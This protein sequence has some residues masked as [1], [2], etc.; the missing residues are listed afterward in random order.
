M[1]LPKFANRSL[2]NIAISTIRGQYPILINGEKENSLFGSGILL[3]LGKNEITSAT[4][5]QRTVTSATPEASVLI[6]K[7]FFAGFKHHNDLQWMDRTE[8]MFLRSIK[9]L[10][11]Y[12]VMQLRTYESLT[13]LEDF[14]RDHQQ[15]NL[16]LFVDAY[17]Q[18]Q[19]LRIPNSQG[20]DNLLNIIGQA[21]SNSLSNLSYDDYKEDILKILQRN[22]FASDI[23]LST[24]IV[25]PTSIENYSTGPGTGVIELTNISSFSTNTSI[26]TDPSPAS[27]VMID[28]YHIMNISEEDIELAINEA[29]VGSV[30]T[31]RA[32]LDSNVSLDNIDTTSIIA[33]GLELLGLGEFDNTIDVKYIRNQLR[34][35]FLG[36]G[37]VNAGDTVH[38]YIR[39]NKSIHQ[40]DD[41]YDES[42]F[43]VD[44][45]IMEAERILFTNKKIDLKTYI[46]LRKYADPSF[47]FNHVYAGLVKESKEAFSNGSWK[48]TVNLEDNMQWLKW[49]RYMF[50]PAID[51]AQGVLEDPLTPYQVK[52]DATGRV[53]SAGGTQLLE[54]NKQLLRSSLLSYDSGI[55]NGQVATENNLLQGQ[56]NQGGSLRNTKILQ[57]PH[58]LVYRW[59]SGIITVT[60]DLNVID[61]LNEESVSAAIHRK[62]YGLTVAQDVLN[63]L[64]VANILSILIVG[65]PYNVN[66][67]L[68]QSYQ[69]QNYNL[70]TGVSS[71][72]SQN[73]LSS[74]LDV[75]RSQNNYFGN[76]RPYRMITLSNNTM[77]ESFSRHLIRGEVNDKLKVLRSRSLEIARKID[78]LK[79]STGSSNN[80]LIRTLTDE[81]SNIQ[82]TIQSQIK[83]AQTTVLSTGAAL[84]EN[85]NLFGNNRV[86]PLTGNFEA[87]SNLTRAIMSV[88]ARRR[89]EDVRL[90]RDQNLFIVNDQYDDNVDIRPFIL[91]FRDSKYKVF[92]GQYVSAY[93]KC[94]SAAKIPN[95]EFSTNSQGHIE[96]RPPQWNKTP[97]SIL[98]EL[99]RLKKEEK[100]NI[101]P[102]FLEDMFETRSSSLKRQ[103][104]QLNIRIVILAFLLGRFP[105][106]RLIPNIGRTGKDSLRF[107]GVKPNNLV[108]PDKTDKSVLRNSI[109]S[110][111]NRLS[112]NVDEFL[113]PQVSLDITLG[114]EG[115]ILNADTVTVLG[116]FDPVFQESV[117]LFNDLLTVNDSSGGSEAYKSGYATPTSVNALREA[118]R[119]SYGTDPAAD[120]TSTNRPMD[121]SDFAIAIAEGDLVVKTEKY[122]S[123]LQQTI[124]ERDRLVTTL[125]LTT[126][127]QKELA[128]LETVLSGE[129]TQENTDTGLLKAIDQARNLTK[130]V[131]DIFTGDATRGSIFDHLVEDDSKNYEGPGS[132]KRFIVQD[133]DIISANFDE[134]P[135]DFTRVSVL[136]NNPFVGDQLQRSFD[137]RYYWAGG[138]DYDMW[139]QYGFIEGAAGDIKLPYANNAELQCRPFAYLELQI[140]RA[141]INKGSL[142]VIG[143]EYYEPSDTIYI[144]TKGLMYYISDVS[145]SFDYEGRFTTTLSL[146]N[147]HPP[148]VYLPGPLDIIGQQYISNDPTATILTYRNIQGDDSYRTLQP[149][150]SIIFPPGPLLNA[151]QLNVLLAYKDNNL[152]FTN[153]M[154]DLSSVML[155]NRLVLIRGFYRNDSDKERVNNNLELVKQL[156][157]KPVMSVQNEPI[158]YQDDFSNLADDIL[159]FA[160]NK[161]RGLGVQTGSS[162]GLVTLQLPNSL[163]PI[164]L[165]PE[166]I[167]IQ[168]VALG[169]EPAS[170]IKCLN[171]VL[172]EKLS[173]GDAAI[174]PKGGPK[175]RTW[176]DFRDD[177]SQVSN[178][179]EIGILDI[180]FKM[181][182]EPRNSVIE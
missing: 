164:T 144:P 24:W 168:T 83:I 3:D 150:S 73:P 132:G 119:S 27:F 37:L 177:L 178:I 131:N 60:A 100:I 15:L 81:L 95:F 91:A 170:Q 5:L 38:F 97:L 158:Q 159:D 20:K 59:K 156:L 82:K 92:K 104:H 9:A 28:P 181:S 122:L 2:E 137:D 50:E 163:P 8:K 33:S 148:G 30:G 62:T 16:N 135:P 101:I 66:S 160:K 154:V 147:G 96:F 128:E 77:E 117:G 68:Q 102:D 52:T 23:R 79:V 55:L 54:E 32:L 53:L 167:V 29:L 166:Q 10:F 120:L 143:N 41:F 84:T 65:Q 72:T 125:N 124:S 14:L 151:S 126:E 105:D 130:A 69:A 139:R 175:Q 1:S 40:K 46:D 127:K 42:Y 116:D 145:H 51:D 146:I 58:G 85:F 169:T 109:Q 7:K 172:S 179:I 87:D 136:G 182:T 112:T 44:E 103:I 47:G 90:N 74:V 153:M 171:S 99:F 114:E 70:G 11:A 45:S 67:F 88:G 113:G 138:T 108:D 118:F 13:K 165:S 36:K 106:R 63:N 129:A 123:K 107:F 34:V 161:V 61:P 155:G 19:L 21:I 57:H 78:N 71:L 56:Y 86:L 94:S 35:F 26:N 64:D 180:N 115:N 49:S 80:L 110:K 43:E 176:L 162:K 17:N 39:S 4:P 142:T 12:K 25:D 174:L 48:V 121:L 18:A 134:T 98:K 173:T 93:E 133:K 111:L 141:K 140:Q 89:I 22:A 152:R 157:L 149:D 31:F 6:K 76:F 75:I